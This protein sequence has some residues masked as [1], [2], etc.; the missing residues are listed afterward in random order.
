M[1]LVGNGAME[2]VWQ[3]LCS[4]AGGYVRRACNSV[5]WDEVPCA[6]VPA[7]MRRPRAC[8][9]RRPLERKRSWPAREGPRR[10]TAGAASIPIGAHRRG[11]RQGSGVAR[12]KSRALS[13]SSARGM[14]VR[15]LRHLAR[16]SHQLTAADADLPIFA[17]LNTARVLD[18]PTGTP[19][20]PDSRSPCE[21]RHLHALAS[22]PGEKCGLTRVQDPA[23]DTNRSLVLP[24]KPHHLPAPFRRCA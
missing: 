21:Y 16:I 18:V 13:E 23:R 11:I 24:R 6:F 12:C 1:R 19:A 7:A 3:G 15:P 8:S 2:F 4:I 10:A 20:R 22:R 14:F 5:Q 9:S 17:A